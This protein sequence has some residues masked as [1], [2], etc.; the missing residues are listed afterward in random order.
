[1]RRGYPRHLPMAHTAHRLWALR[2]PQCHTGCV[3]DITLY[4]SPSL[5][6]PAEPRAR[7]K[8]QR[9]AAPALRQPQVGEK[10][11]RGVPVKLRPLLQAALRAVLGLSRAVSGAPRGSALGMG[12]EAESGE[13]S[14]GQLWRGTRGGRG[15]EGHRGSALD[16]DTEG[17]AAKPGLGGTPGVSPAG[18]HGTGATTAPCSPPKCGVSGCPQ[19][20]QPSPSPAGG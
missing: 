3:L 20:P 2:A 13:D 15:G 6:P 7:P 8:P 16:G 14:G 4:C 5:A 19:T 18:P 11:G 9:A 12:W 1:M 10:R 17:W